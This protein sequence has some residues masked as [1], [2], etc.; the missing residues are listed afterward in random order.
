MT[1]A[2]P[3]RRRGYF[4]GVAV[5]VFS[6]FLGAY[7]RGSRDVAMKEHEGCAQVTISG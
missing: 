2:P 5:Q 1:E 4:T 7:L 6:E 3:L